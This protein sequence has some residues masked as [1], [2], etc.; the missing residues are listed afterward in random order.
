MPT[1][2][3]PVWSCLQR[4]T[5]PFAISAYA[6]S[7]TASAREPRATPAHATTTRPIPD[8]CAARICSPSN[9]SP[10]PAATT[11]SE[12]I[13]TP[14]TA[15]VIRRKA[16][17]SMAC[18]SSDQSTATAA[19]AAKPPHQ[20]GEQ[21]REHDPAAR[22]RYRRREC[23][24]MLG[25]DPAELDADHRGDHEHRG[26]HTSARRDQPRRESQGSVLGG[27][28]DHVV[29]RSRTRLRMGRRALSDAGGSAA[30]PDSARRLICGR[31]V[32]GCVSAEQ[33]W[34]RTVPAAVLGRNEPTAPN[35]RSPQ[36]S[37]ELCGKSRTNRTKVTGFGD[38]CAACTPAAQ[39]R[40]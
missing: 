20:H 23:E 7:P 40:T 19:E 4:W 38:L 3:K 14:N 34:T 32:V 35:L 17:I 39:P 11:G 1:S 13:M 36:I 8:H 33:T 9:S 37:V 15:G 10:T 26:G 27:T 31:E 22:D 29:L 28:D 16:A 30:R 25:D 24:Q 5:P 12:L 21:A 2:G 18:G 6:R